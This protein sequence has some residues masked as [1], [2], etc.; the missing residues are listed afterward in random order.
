MRGFPIAIS[1]RGWK[2][3]DDSNKSKINIATPNKMRGAT[4]YTTPARAMAPA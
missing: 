2:L 1:R 4:C 3:E